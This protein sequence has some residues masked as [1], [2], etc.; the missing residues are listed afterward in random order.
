MWALLGAVWT[1]LVQLVALILR[2]FLEVFAVFFLQLPIVIFVAKQHL[3]NPCAP[4]TCAE[5]HDQDK[6][7]KMSRRE[8][9]KTEA[10]QTLNRETPLNSMFTGR[11]LVGWGSLRLLHLLLPAWI[12]YRWRRKHSGALAHRLYRRDTNRTGRGPQNPR[13]LTME[14]CT[15]TARLGLP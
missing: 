7:Y 13:S 6:G 4:K 3:L 14:G 9:C 12:V 15:L 2:G 1:Y 5:D 8:P 11:L 10:H